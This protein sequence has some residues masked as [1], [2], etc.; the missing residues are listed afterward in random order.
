MRSEDAPGRRVTGV[1]E[2]LLD[3]EWET[4]GE[5]EGEGRRWGAASRCRDGEE[6]WGR[7]GNLSTERA[8]AGAPVLGVKWRSVLD[9]APPTLAGSP[10]TSAPSSSHGAPG[11]HPRTSLQV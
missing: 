4:A 9:N 10:G 8:G 6:V 11:S 2:L 3:E 7:A 5:R 1:S